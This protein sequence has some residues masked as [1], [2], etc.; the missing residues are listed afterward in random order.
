MTSGPSLQRKTNVRRHEVIQPIGETYRLIPLTR[1]QNAIVDAEDFEQLNRFN[2]YAE[3][4]KT[5]K[6]FYAA[7]RD[8]G[9]KY[10]SMHRFVMSAGPDFEVD[11]ISHDTLDNRKGNLRE[12]TSQHNN[13]NTRIRSDNTSGFKGVSWSKKLKKWWS[14]IRVNGKTL[15]LGYH[16]KIEDAARAYDAA[17]RKHFGEFASTNF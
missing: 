11:H 4:S 14:N 2:W 15:H 9:G 1:N 17:A 16:E 13:C 3:W 6:S 10:L 5:T 12:C 8:E 7:R